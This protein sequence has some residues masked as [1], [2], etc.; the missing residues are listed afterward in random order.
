MKW[1]FW[2]E[3]RQNRVVFIALAV[4]LVVPHLFGAA[5]FVIKTM[6]YHEYL[7]EGLRGILFGASLYSL[8]LSQV[9]LALI[10]GNVIAGERADRS[11]EFQAYLPLSRQRILG[12]KLLVV[13]TVAAVIWTINP[14]IMLSLMGSLFRP[15]DIN[16]SFFVQITANIA[17]TGVAFF[18]VAWL[19]SSVLSSSTISVVA[20]LVAPVVIWSG[21]CFVN[22]LIQGDVWSPNTQYVLQWSY[23]SICLAVSVICFVAGTWIFL[24]RVEA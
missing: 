3:Y 9:A 5:I 2:K 14:L 22:Y 24:R 7:A 20:G 6:Y 21:I 23:W 12:G 16:Y 1:L 19:L 8:G 18:G 17:I 11:A 13:L 4:M 15:G 10:G